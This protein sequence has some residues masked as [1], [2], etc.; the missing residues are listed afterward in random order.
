MP[1]EVMHAFYMASQSIRK[2]CKAT[3]APVRAL[4]RSSGLSEQ[5]VRWAIE[6]ELGTLDRAAVRKRL[7]AEAKKRQVE[8]TRMCMIILAGNLFSAAFRATLFALLCGYHVVVKASSKDA[9]FAKLLYQHL[10]K[11]HPKLGRRIRVLSYRGADS[12]N[13]HLTDALLARADRVIAYGSDATLDALRARMPK[14]TPLIEHGHGLG[15]VFVDTK[16]L[17]SP[18]SHSAL[19]VKLATD[20]AAYDQRGCL[21]PQGIWLQADDNTARAFCMKLLERGLKPIEQ[22][23]PRGPMPLEERVVHSQWRLAAQAQGALFA[24]QTSGIA[25]FA[26]RPFRLT[27]GR[28]EVGVYRCDSLASFGV[29]AVRLGEHVK[30]IASS[31]PKQVQ[32]F[33][34]RHWPQVSKPRV[35]AIGQMQTPAIDAWWDG[36]SPWF[37]LEAR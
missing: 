35:C 7:I 6:H 12:K 22:W 10:C 31:Q 34:D 17:R 4:A 11:V 8:P 26:K 19:I 14:H 29:Q 23:M 27:P 36:R 33:V 3:R 5:G 20:I 30:L 24:T 32:R 18:R 28:R 9:A 1:T 37:G 2:A 25:Y 15:L 16:T 13:Q 21:S